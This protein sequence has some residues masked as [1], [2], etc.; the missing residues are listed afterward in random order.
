MLMIS[1]VL[2]MSSFS[3]IKCSTIG[4]GIF[5]EKSDIDI[6]NIVTK[7]SLSPRHESIV[8]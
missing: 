2:K 7:P 3:S 6:N 1:S 8:Q 4:S 5:Y